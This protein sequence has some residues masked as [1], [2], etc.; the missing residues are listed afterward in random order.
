MQNTG[1][2]LQTTGLG[3]ELF[4]IQ[5]NTSFELQ[6]NLFVIHIGKP[7]ITNLPDIDVSMLPN[8][9]IVS[10]HHAEIQIEGSNYYIVDLGSSNGTYLNNTK[11]EPR[12]RYPLQIGDRIDLGR[13]SKVS[14]ILQ[15]KQNHT[16]NVPLMQPG[17]AAYTRQT[18]VDRTS[19][20]LGSVLI[21]ASV[22]ILAAST[23]V[24]LF[25]RLPGVL[26]S[27]AGVVVLL[28]VRV[29]RIIGWLLILGGIAVI[30][31]TGGMF[32]SVNLLAVLVACALLT[33]GYQ[34][35]TTGKVWKYDLPT[36]Q[37]FVKQRRN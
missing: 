22:L 15:Y 20:L 3:L 24:G 21:V 11:L 4:H 8:A 35:F 19:K 16:Q 29:N 14:F 13:G 33:A 27:I 9:D 25:V 26:I 18:Q 17:V 12:T 5:S 6:E 23:Q 28:V 37:G 2:T 34:L 1:T 36:L 31:F 32:A 30:A 10:R 7:D